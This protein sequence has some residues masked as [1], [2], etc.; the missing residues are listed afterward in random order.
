MFDMVREFAYGLK[1]GV[2]H[3]VTARHNMVET[4]ARPSVAA[5]IKNQPVGNDQVGR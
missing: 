5:A 3:S 1:L 4:I 2:R